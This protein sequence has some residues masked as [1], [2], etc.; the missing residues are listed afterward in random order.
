MTLIPQSR[1]PA[2][3]QTGGSERKAHHALPSG[4]KGSGRPDDRTIPDDFPSLYGGRNFPPSDGDDFLEISS[5]GPF[6]HS[7]H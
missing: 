2:A 5:I 1:L 7:L 3:T 6:S 4:E